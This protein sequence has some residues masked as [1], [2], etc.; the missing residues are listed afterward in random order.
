MEIRNEGKSNDDVQKLSCVEKF[1]KLFAQLEHCN[2]TEQKQKILEMNEIIDGVNNEEFDSIF[3]KELFNKIDKMIEEKKITIKNAI[4]LMKHAGYNKVLLNFECYG[5]YNSLLSKK[6][7]KMLVDKDK[8]TKEK[9]EKLRTD[10]CECCLFLNC[11]FSYELVSICVPCLLKVATNKDERKETQKDV[12][13][14]LLAL[15]QIGYCEIEQKLYLKEIKEIIEYHQEHRNL[16]RL[17]YRS[18]WEFSMIRLFR[19]RSLGQ[20]IVNELHFGREARREIEELTRCNGW[21]KKPEEM[22]KEE[23]NEVLVIR[24]WIQT[25]N[26]YF[27]NYHLYNEEFDK[28][29][30]CISCVFRAAKDNHKGI[31]DLCIYS[32]RNATE[33]GVVK[34]DVLLKSGAADAVLDGVQRPT[35]SEGVACECLWF[36]LNIPRRLKEEEEDEREEAKRKATKKEFLEKMEEEGYEDIIT[37][38]YETF[39]FLGK[40]NHVYLSINIYDY[41]VNV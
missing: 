11:V 12:E 17:A 8:K 1:S 33:R 18:A 37:S 10:L 2:E 41:F 9:N 40:K 3:T 39:D 20:V 27:C 16:T 30:S 38:F 13:I 19:D 22:S 14:A 31:S 29:F 4:Y 36:F 6:F 28:I 15:S 7:E 34:V 26:S 32:L 21:K 5:F 24:R 35:L 23:A 25:L